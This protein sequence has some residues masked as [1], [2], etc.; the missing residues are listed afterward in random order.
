[1]WSKGPDVI[2]EQVFNNSFSVSNSNLSM[3]VFFHS[4]H[5]LS[6]WAAK[7]VMKNKLH[8]RSLYDR[9]TFLG[10]NQSKMMFGGFS[11][12]QNSQDFFETFWAV[13]KLKKTRLS[14]YKL[15]HKIHFI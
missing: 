1:M 15:N 6:Q 7:W 2:L 3:G 12:L 9:E 5:P 8:L 11:N 13:G 10:I 14:S 4:I